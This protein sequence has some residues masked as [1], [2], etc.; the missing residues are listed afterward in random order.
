MPA[1][2]RAFLF[3]MDGVIVDSNPLH[4]VVWAEYNRRH[5]IETTE[6]MQRRMYGKRNDEIVRDFFGAAISD[7]EV[8]QHGAAKE[9]LYREM[10]RPQIATSLVAGVR[11]F[12]EH[13]RDIPAAVAT[14]AESANLDFVLDE[15]GLRP[16]FRVAVDGHQVERP[17][18]FPDLYLCA[19]RKLGVEP[20]HCVVFEDSY[21]GVE[22]G[23]SA[24]MRVIGVSTTH[25]DLRGISLLIPDFTD[26]ALEAWLA[27]KL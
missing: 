21:T 26:P 16:Y 19:A 10:L 11:D 13:H 22:A 8:F 25:P 3:D 6:A 1:E 18:P 9:A 24:G 15:S 17:K 12:L 27:P 20:E 5:G 2:I 23:I 14:N 4:R 7:E